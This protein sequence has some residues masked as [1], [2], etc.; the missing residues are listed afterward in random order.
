[1]ALLCPYL[2]SWDFLAPVSVAKVLL[3]RTYVSLPEPTASLPVPDFLSIADAHM[4]E[5]S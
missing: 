1:V 4:T 2:I 3:F 5:C